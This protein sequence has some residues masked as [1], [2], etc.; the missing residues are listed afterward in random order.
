LEDTQQEVALRE[1]ELEVA[2]AELQIVSADDLADARQDLAVAERQA[3]EA[4][5]KLQLLAAGSRPE[6]IEATEAEI[7]RLEAQQRYLTEQLR[8]TAVRSPA[9]GI[10]T[11]PKVKEKVGEHLDQGDLIVEVYE[12]DRVTPE[13]LISE[14]EIADVR[15]GQKV[16]LKARAYPGESFHGTVQAIAPAAIE[17]KGVGRKVFRV[18]VAMDGPADLL[19]PEMTG[20]AKILCGGRTVWHLL[21]RRVARYVRVEFWSWW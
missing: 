2:Q 4:D 9:A 12:L 10:L 21:T 6:M 3:T 1:K 17:D 7:A 19:K 18:T 14:K 5:G 13:V 15:P 8:L 11:T 20:Q 16:V